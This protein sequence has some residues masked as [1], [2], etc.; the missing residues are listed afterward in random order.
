MAATA[1][2]EDMAILDMEEASTEALSG[3]PTLDPNQLS[4]LR[5]LSDEV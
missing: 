2:M 1:V 4:A 5:R 3:A